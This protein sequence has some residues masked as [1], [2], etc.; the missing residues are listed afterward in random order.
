[1]IEHLIRKATCRVS[2]GTESGTGWLI[3]ENRIV[4]ARHCVLA[5]IEEGKLVELLFPDSGEV[6]IAGTIVAHSEDWDACLLSTES[7]P[8]INPLPLSLEL[9]REGEAWQTFGYPGSKSAIG[10][11]LT[12]T[13]AQTL[14]IPKQ[15]IDIDLSIDPLTALQA[16]NGMSGGA[17]VCKGVVVG[18]I[19]KKFDGT[20]AALSLNALEG[21]LADNGVFP[22]G[23]SS[24]PSPPPLADRGD[25]P[26]TFAKE[27]QK[28]SA[29][30][31]F[32]EGAHGYGKSTFCRHFQA[33]EAKLTSLGAYCL[34]DPDSAL[35]ANYRAQPQ[36][37]L[38]W[39][40]TK[41]SGLIIGH[42]PLKEEKAY[43]EQVRETAAYLNAFSQHAKQ[44]G[45][46]GVFFIDGLN[47]IPGGTMLDTLLGLFPAKLPPHVSVVFTAP[48]FDNVAVAL[49]G[50]VKSADVF[51]LPPL[52]DSAC[53]RYCQKALKPERRA[54][55]LI[56]RICQ[57]AKGHPLYLRYLIEYANLQATDDVLDGFPVLTGPIEDYYRGIW[58]KLLSDG[59]AVNLLA[60][61]ARLRWGV[62]LADFSKAL[63]FGEQTQFVSVLSRIRHLL[64]DDQTTAI[65]HASFAA[66]IIEQTVRI[67]ESACRRLAKFC[68]EEP[69][70]RYCALN[71]IFHLSL[72]GDNLVFAECNQD[73]FD[74]AVTLGV[75]P[76]A[77]IADVD[78]VVKRAAIEAS[79][80]E[81]FRLTFLAQ[82]I[83]FRYNTLFAQSARLIAESLIVLARPL[84]ALQHVLRLKTLIVGLDDALE[85]AF[86]LHRHGYNAEALTLLDRVQQRIVE[87]YDTPVPLADFFRL[88]SWHIQTIF[89]VRLADGHNGMKQVI[90]LM[91]MA[92]KV[93]D[94]ELKEAPS[95]K[96]E[97]LSPILA[98]SPTYFLT[99]RDEY[100]DIERLKTFQKDEGL[101]ETGLPPHHL[102]I[103]CVAL[104]NFE[105]TV[106]KYHMPKSRNALAKLFED[107][108]E[109]IQN[110]EI[111]ASLAGAVSDTLI[112]FGASASVV[113]GFA[114]KAGKHLARPLQIKAKNGVDVNHGDLLECLSDWRVAA[115]LDST[116]RG[117]SFGIIAGTG[118]FELLEHLIGAL[119]HCDGRARRAKIDSDETA[120]T[121]CRDQLK[122]QVIE[123]LRFT[124]QQRA[125]WADSY[126]IPE[127]AL[128]RVFWQLSELLSDCFP[129]ELP[130][131]L[132]SLVAGAD[133]QWGMYSEGFRASACQVL[134]QLTR[135]KPS[136][137]L[138]PKLL[139]LL[140]AWRDHV[141][142]GVENRH[143]LVPELLRMIPIFSHLGATE[144]AERLY[145]QLL[146]VSMGPTWYKED[147][148][149][150]MTEVLG[151]ISVSKEIVPR[152]SK[153]A[154]YLEKA[155]GEMTFQRYVRAEKSSL[156]GQI[157]R[158]G[159]YRAAAEYFRRQ[160]CGSIPELWAEAQQGPIDK[161]GPLKGNRFPGGALDDQDAILAMVRH[162][163]VVAW[164]LRWALLE[165]FHCGDS[166]HLTD[167]AEAFANIANEV[168]VLP[169]LIHRMEIVADA[170]TPSGA[171]ASVASAFRSALKPE[172]HA[173]F[174][175]VLAGLP[176]VKPPTPPTPRVD[177]EKVDDDAESGFFNPGVFGRQRALQDA[178]DILAAAE[179]ELSLGNR[180][181]A[182]AKAVTVL[183]TAQEGGWGIW[184]NL[185]PGTRRAKEIL[186]QDEV[187]AANVI[188]YYAPLIDAEL[189][190]PKWT[191][192]QYLIGKVGPL[193][194]EAEGQRLLDAVIEHCRLVVGDA[195]QEI[196]TFDFLND[197]TPEPSPEVEYF[198][199]IVWLCNHPQWLRRERA[200]ALLLW[201]VERVPK[202]F[203]EAVNI[204]FSMEEGYGPDV[205]CGVLDGA[206]AREPAVLWE[207]VA[208][209]LNLTSV[210]QEL[211][212]ISR[213]IVLERL[214]T[215]GDKAGSSTAKSAL[216]QLSFPSSSIRATVGHS[217]LPKWGG[218]L[219]RQ[220]RQ[221]GKC[222][223]AEF[224][225][226][227]EK[228]LEKLC[229]PLSITD[230]LS[231]EAAVST[232][233]R[234]YQNRPFDRW[235]SKLRHA[236]NLALWN[237]VS[238]EDARMVEAT[239]RV[240]NPSQPERTV[241]GMSNPVTDQLLAAIKSEDYSA[242]F[243]SNPFA[244]L[245]YHDMVANSTEGG[246]E[247]IEVLC[248]L[249]PASN[250][251]GLSGRQL[252]QSFLS[253]EMP[254]ASTVS[255]PF[256][257]CCRLQPEIVFFG[258]FTPPAPIQ[259]FQSLLGVRNGDFVRKHWRFGRRN[260]SP[261]FGQPAREG[262][263]LSV[264]RSALKIPPG[265]KL[266]WIV[267][268][269]G[270]VVTVVDERNNQLL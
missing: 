264:P 219:A 244:L 197:E 242:V 193:L 66:F 118:W 58:A 241:L 51:V 72:A 100:A 112:R 155:S 25:F 121:T 183:K 150:I 64:A 65:Y 135:E 189:Y 218:R 236:L 4:T 16:Y 145:L 201:I 109:L 190:V 140:R 270:K 18:F 260:E 52:P 83:T 136:D 157:A 34:S 210:K 153:V 181:E 256:E 108:D 178:D 28:R 81:F 265:F 91:Q 225:T 107:L 232:S 231:L 102:L 95:R 152:L 240:Y 259:F 103:H 249:Q 61:M 40:T 170:E 223:D 215:R 6:A 139:G 89:L 237:Y 41:I 203:S 73:W 255:T 99:F 54:S 104:L 116:F 114:A 234:E 128:P 146:S 143:E 26:E 217:K 98:S 134:E 120:R 55:A 235:E 130:E 37:F 68:R 94:E 254:V 202:L 27:V 110:G 44:S 228:E 79:P 63:N 10:H 97:I 12:G 262:C 159:R 96:I 227:W 123:P 75:E 53:Y 60:L 247:H 165:I 221:F 177:R 20:V 175:T 209:A 253:S 105:T 161:V 122:A 263:S 169:E 167:Y 163:R 87:S 216:A 111:D 21:F 206:S 156:L 90:A 182:K 186:F 233:F 261:G 5:G 23:V 192:A 141:L 82:R 238:R 33:D 13:V 106:D 187:N 214:A 138:A 39:L 151:S 268:V 71:R 207:N 246:A 24:N 179:K 174:A 77:L 127:N 266:V 2:C 45:R 15:K 11:R 43:P 38:D 220:W 248:L 251:R 22:P 230:V 115:F 36:V 172:L 147:Q 213:L 101:P 205:L 198:R 185:S 250:Q 252:E 1:M 50:R 62:S 258:P 84:E 267:W 196:Q 133:G 80:D 164:E 243:G 200:A 14:N 184:G 19:S 3:G 88:C 7:T 92:G 204:A 154:G 76:D 42:P 69:S 29:S 149:G 86:L 113:A 129:E 119:Y 194:S 8:L 160:C 132:D 117:P 208:M 222:I 93:C 173:A 131:W 35:G 212:H 158:Q 125:T 171:R 226:A 17:V 49:A 30:Y 188:R 57:K 137:E 191:P 126:A 199:F 47:E 148:L 162:S 124:L 78:S 85:I 9:P 74:T 67:D 46:H 245:N 195:K 229:S 31:I 166:R 70:V 257:T 32:L 168:G 211:R 239:L 142:R 176:P 56:D 144:E 224:V 180:N 269:D 59:D 48:N